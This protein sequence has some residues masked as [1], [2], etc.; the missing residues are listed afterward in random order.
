MF[1]PQL[2]PDLRSD[3]CRQDVGHE[4]IIWSPIRE[5]PFAMD[6]VATVMLD[7][8]DGNATLA[9]L[10]EDVHMVVGVPAEVAELQVQR[11]VHLL[12][13]AGALTISTGEDTTERHRELFANPPST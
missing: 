7:V 9:D 6:P 12:D 1:D 10:A 3:L 5:D 8:I 11:V 4:A 13:Q 2:V